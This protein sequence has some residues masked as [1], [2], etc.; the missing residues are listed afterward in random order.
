MGQ[1]FNVVAVLW[2][3][4]EFYRA[5]NWFATLVIVTTPEEGARSNNTF[6]GHR[7][8]NL[9]PEGRRRMSDM[10]AAAEELARK[11]VYPPTRPGCNAVKPQALERLA[12]YKQP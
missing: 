3:I 2:L 9:T 1:P 10:L 11:G 6:A 12:R 5:S 8:V 7:D 4:Q